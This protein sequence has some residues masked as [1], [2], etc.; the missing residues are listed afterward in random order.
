MHCFSWVWYIRRRFA[1]WSKSTSWPSNSGPSTQVNFVFPPTE[2]RQ[3]PHIPVASTMIELSETMVLI[4]C[5]FVTLA[6]DPHHRHGADRVDAV[7]LLPRID[8]VL[9][10]CAHEAVEAVAPVVGGHDQ[11]VAHP[12][13]LLLEDEEPFVLAPMMEVTW[14]PAFFRAAAS[15]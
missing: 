14:F 2:T 3:A 11:P 8:Q 1:S 15:G 7:D 13:H 12:L 4:P 6:Q 10:N 5:G 9:E